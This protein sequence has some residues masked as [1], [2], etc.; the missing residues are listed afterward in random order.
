MGGFDCF[1]KI[2][3]ANCNIILSIYYPFINREELKKVLPH[4][5]F[6][7]MTTEDLALLV[8]PTNILS[9]AQVISLFTYIG[10][11]QADRE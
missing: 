9:N 4:I 7:N 10:A 11:K 5:R 3:I 6:P 8:N 1:G 2:Y